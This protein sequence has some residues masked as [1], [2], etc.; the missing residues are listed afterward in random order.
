MRSL[1]L[2]VL[3]VEALVCRLL[4]ISQGI[5]GLSSSSPFALWEKLHQPQGLAQGPI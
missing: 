1:Q 3:R 5:R 4:V 2:C